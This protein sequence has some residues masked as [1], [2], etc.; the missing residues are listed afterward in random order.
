MREKSGKC[1]ILTPQQ[2]AI[3]W[4]K[5][6]RAFYINKLLFPSI[7][8]NITNINMLENIT[9]QIIF[10]GVQEKT[11]KNFPARNMC[12]KKKSQKKEKKSTNWIALYLYYTSK[13]KSN[14]IL[15]AC[16]LIHLRMLTKMLTYKT[17]L[18]LFHCIWLPFFTIIIRAHMWYHHVVVFLSYHFLL[19]KCKRVCIYYTLCMPDIVVIVIYQ[20]E[21][22]EKNHIISCKVKVIPLKNHIAI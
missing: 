8:R 2:C 20:R 3:C 16:N 9:L 11:S 4:I 14:Y 17:F 15:L 12:G 22:E 10:I 18:I 21:S 19:G 6:V 5:C 7:E 1:I 13:K